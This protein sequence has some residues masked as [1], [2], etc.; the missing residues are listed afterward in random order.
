MSEKGEG[1]PTKLFPDLNKS[2]LVDKAVKVAK[3]DGN[4]IDENSK[5][6]RFNAFI[7][8]ALYGGN[9]EDNPDLS[10]MGKVFNNP[11][12]SDRQARLKRFKEELLYPE[13]LLISDD[14][15]PDSYFELQLKIAR[16]R[17]QAGDLNMNGIKTIAYIPAETRREAGEIIYN[18]Q[19]QSLDTW[20]DYLSSPDA[21]YP[22]W[23]KYYVLRSVVKMGVYDKEKHEFSK[24]TKD[25]TAIF[26]DLNREALSYSYDTLSK[27]YVKGEK[28][29]DEELQKILESAK[30]SKI[31]AFAIDKA[32]PASKESKE[33]T[34]G[35]WTKFNQGDDATPLYES[36]QG[37]GTEWCIAGESVAENYLSQGDIYIYYTKDK[38]GKNTIPRVAI[39]MEN[40]FVAEVRGIEKDQNLEG[41]MT[42]IAKEKYHQLPGGEKFDKKDHDMKLLTLIDNKVNKNQELTK[43]ELLFLYQIDNQIEGFGF[44]ADPRIEEILEKRSPKL[45]A[46]IFF[47]C[48]PNE[49]AWSQKELNNSKKVYIGPLFTGI[50]KDYQNIDHIYTSFPEGKISRESLNI[51]GKSVDQLENELKQN[52]INIS[53]YA[54]EIMKK[55]E[56]TTLKS[57]ENFD[58]I[59][60][61][62]SDLGFTTYMPTTDQIYKTA[63]QFGLELCPPEVGPELR[64]KYKDQ[65]LGEYKEIAI[66]QIGG[67]LSIF[68]IGH[69]DNGLLLSAYWTFSASHWYIDKRLFFIL[70]K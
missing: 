68:E 37:H 52:N 4:R 64:L 39:R 51:G 20:V 62:V 30:F 70:R 15:V 50:F 16:E 11:N 21:Q 36:L 10:M 25:T 57:T 7:G 22:T 48:H 34:E 31:Y 29:D 1:I 6:S 9:P 5:E 24:R 53:S 69:D 3:F 59:Y 27:Y 65:P 33:K 41:N 40:G 66:K 61:R 18:D 14:N 60:L 42:E 12:E 46:P 43:E 28:H 13:V 49:I 58:L 44:Q 32:T 47:G 35:E 26:P 19:K 56:F 67:P 8:D 45:D 17:G 63:K 2:P 23:F 55:P 54:K 38:D